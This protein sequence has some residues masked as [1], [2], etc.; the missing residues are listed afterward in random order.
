[1]DVELP[2]SGLMVLGRRL[3]RQQQRNQFWVARAELEA[4]D[5]APKLEETLFP[6]ATRLIGEEYRD[7]LT[8]KLA[9]RRAGLRD[10]WLRGNREALGETRCSA[11]LRPQGEPRN[12]AARH[13]AEQQSTHL[14]MLQHIDEGYLHILITKAALVLGDE[15]WLAEFPSWLPWPT[16]SPTR[17][18][19]GRSRYEFTDLGGQRRSLAYDCD[20]RLIPQVLAIHTA[21]RSGAP[22]A[23][24][25]AAR[26]RPSPA[27]AE[28][29]K[30][31]ITDLYCYR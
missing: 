1:M 26:A 31:N 13:L 17:V 20:Q 23:G 21:Y 5:K 19:R 9:Y 16:R 3:G 18:L 8:A 12:E 10:N 29:A 4:L 7:H 15:E 2:A 24:G 22:L 14:S 6:G 11:N 28:R 25:I 27:Q 30:T